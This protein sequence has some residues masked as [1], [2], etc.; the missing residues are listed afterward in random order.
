MERLNM[1]DG[2]WIPSTARVG[3]NH[4]PPQFLA[5]TYLS[6]NGSH[7]AVQV[8]EVVDRGILSL[9][10]DRRAMDVIGVEGPNR[11]RTFQAIYAL[12]EDQLTVCYA[13]SG[14]ARPTDFDTCHDPNLYLISYIRER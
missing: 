1:L 8:G 2:V 14:D 9:D 10:P 4:L 5:S 6:I 11:G 3:A 7:Y 12:E 13:L